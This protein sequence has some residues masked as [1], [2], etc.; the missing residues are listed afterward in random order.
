MCV[1]HANLDGCI[2]VP[3]A[4]LTWKLRRVEHCCRGAFFVLPSSEKRHA[5]VACHE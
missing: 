5:T 2:V 4:G 3:H 1:F